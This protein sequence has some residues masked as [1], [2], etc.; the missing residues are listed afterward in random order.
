MRFVEDVQA[1]LKAQAEPAAASAVAEPDLER[2]RALLWNA[3]EDVAGQEGK[4]AA[5]ARWSAPLYFESFVEGVAQALTGGIGK[6]WS[7]D[8]LQQVL[9]HAL[10][11]E[12]RGTAVNAKKVG[13]AV[14]AL[15]VNRVL[16]QVRIEQSGHTSTLAERAANALRFSR[17]SRG[18]G[19]VGVGGQLSP[20]GRVLIGLVGREAVRFI[21][22]LEVALSTGWSDSDRV[23]RSGLSALVAGRISTHYSED[24][25]NFHDIFI[26]MERMAALGIAEVAWDDLNG[27]RHARPTPDATD[28]I[29]TVLDPA[30]N[31]YRALV[32]ALLDAERG[33]LTSTVT[34]AAPAMGSDLAYVRMIVHELRNATV[35]LAHAVAGVWQ[36]LER[37]DRPDP[38]RIAELRERV[39]R[40]LG[41]ITTFTEDSARLAQAVSDEAFSLL[42]VVGEAIHAT[43]ADRNG[44]IDVV[45]DALTDATIEGARGR[46]VL[47][48]VNLL[49]NSAQGRAGKGSVWIRS[50]WPVGGTLHIYVDDDGPGVPEELRERI[51]DLGVSQRGGSGI[52]LADA[53]TTVLMSRGTLVCEAGPEDGARF[54]IHVPAR[55]RP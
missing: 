19:A 38:A 17:W 20:V 45:L 48:F 53:R 31:P 43:S 55:R 24:P 4:E 9:G 46:W 42:D 2:L 18:V 50:V 28:L 30:P 52:G 11:A 40:A 23:S 44:R 47:L 51:F 35:P 10:R 34:G 8:R 37:P 16:L 25:S 7:A 13:G 36:E 29:A 1:W 26:A 21:L 14:A 3:L 33:R 22:E 39:D 41:R 5:H 32:S 15:E 6:G 12:V 54:H 27:L 49:R